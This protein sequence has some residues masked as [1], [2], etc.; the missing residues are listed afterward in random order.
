MKLPKM[1]LSLL[2]LVAANVVPLVGVVL[3]GWDA[4]VIVLLYWTENLVIGFY[5]ILK[6]AMVKAP[7]STVQNSKL[8]V[9][10]FFCLHFGAFCAGHG[11]FLYG[12][13]I[14]MRR[15]GHKKPVQIIL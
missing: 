6:M 11:F 3:L 12:L 13:A 10:P 1:T 2:A 4:A 9:I 14:F 15:K 5:N 7:H 8:F